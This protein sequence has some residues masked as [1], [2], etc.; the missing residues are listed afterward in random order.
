MSIG[1]MIITVVG[2]AIGL[3]S[4]GYLVIGIPAV[5]FWKFYRK[6]RYHISLND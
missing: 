3:L 5:I 4:T 1:M 2:G 6:I